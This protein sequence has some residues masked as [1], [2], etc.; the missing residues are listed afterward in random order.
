MFGDDKV[1]VM[2]QNE[3]ETAKS[4]ICAG[5]LRNPLLRAQTPTAYSPS[6]QPHLLSSETQTLS[7]VEYLL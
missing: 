1:F 4:D 2:V 3:T 6:H 5:F 7:N